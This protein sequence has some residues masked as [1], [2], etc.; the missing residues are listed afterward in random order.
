[1]TRLPAWYFVVDPKECIPWLEAGLRARPEAGLRGRLEASLAMLLLYY[2]RARARGLAE[3]SLSRLHDPAWIAFAWT[4]VGNASSEDAPVAAAQAYEA[5]LRV[6]EDAGLEA[7]VRGLTV[8]LAV[9]AASARDWAGAMRLVDEAL[10]ADDPVTQAVA[11][12]VRAVVHL[13]RGAPTTA[14]AEVERGLR[15]VR[16]HTPVWLGF[17]VQLAAAIDV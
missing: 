5:A 1:V 10:T 12:Q 11:C 9:A 13:H 15:L 8:N 17:F 7:W 14:R 4:T 16:V 6:A 3:A 2:D